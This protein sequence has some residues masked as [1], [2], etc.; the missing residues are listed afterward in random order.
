MVY[1]YVHGYWWLDGLWRIKHLAF[2]GRCT[3]SSAIWHG[4]SNCVR[5]FIVDNNLHRNVFI[6][7][8][9]CKTESEKHG[10]SSVGETA[11]S[12]VEQMRWIWKWLLCECEIQLMCPEAAYLYCESVSERLLH[13]QTALLNAWVSLG[14]LLATG[15]IIQ[16][17]TYANSPLQFCHQISGCRETKLRTVRLGQGLTSYLRGVF[18]KINY[19]C[20]FHPSS[21]ELTTIF[22]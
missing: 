16:W 14:A 3:W 13:P 20:K 5:C 19:G 15:S 12:H 1:I 10:G 18:P 22:S 17:Y 2:L 8:M 9:N 21:M 7:T 11:C 4:A 6:K